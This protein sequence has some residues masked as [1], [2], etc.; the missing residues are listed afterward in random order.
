MS[1]ENVNVNV[2]ELTADQ[3]LNGEKKSKKRGL[4][5]TPPTKPST[6]TKFCK[7]CTSYTRP[8]CREEQKYTQRKKTCSKFLLSKKASRNAG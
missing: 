8:L 6:E 2:V 3:V 1:K 4:Q 7:D 5:Y